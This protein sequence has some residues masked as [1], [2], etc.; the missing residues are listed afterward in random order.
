MRTAIASV[1]IL[2]LSCA[3]PAP[4]L[5]QPR[6]E[7]ARDH[8]RPAARFV[9]PQTL[10]AVPE[11]T[12][13]LKAVSCF[14]DAAVAD[15][16]DNALKLKT[17]F[18]SMLLRPLNAHPNYR[19]QMCT[20]AFDVFRRGMHTHRFAKGCISAPPPREARRPCGHQGHPRHPFL[21]GLHQGSPVLRVQHARE[22]ARAHLGVREDRPTPDGE[23]PA[24]QTGSG[25]LVRPE[26]VEGG[27]EEQPAGE[28]VPELR[29]ACSAGV[30]E[31]P[32]MRWLVVI[33][34]VFLVACEPEI[35]EGKFRCD[36]YGPYSCPV[37]F[38]CLPIAAEYQCF[39]SRGT[40]G[41]GI[42]EAGEQCD[43]DDFGGFLCSDY[44]EIYE[45]DIPQCTILCTINCSVCG[46]GYVDMHEV[47]DDGNATSG[48]GCSS[49]CRSDETCGNG[50]C[51]AVSGETCSTCPDDCPSISAGSDH[52]CAVESDGTAWCWG[53]NDRGQ[54]GNGSIE[55]SSTP[56]QVTGIVS[57][58]AVSAGTWHSCAVESDGSAWCW[59]RNYYG[60]LGNGTTEDS[61]TLVQVT[62]LTSTVAI[63]AAYYHSCAVE[64]DGSAW[65]WGYNGH[66]QLGD[67]ST[68]GSSTPVQVS[69]IEDAVAISTGK[70]HSCA[71]RTDGTVWC[72]GDGEVGQLGNGSALISS[73]PVQVS[74]LTNAVAV[75]AG[76]LHSC[77]VESDGTA[78]CWG[79]GEYGQ[80]GNGSM[81]DSS[82]PVQVKGLTNAVNISA[83]EGHSCAMLDSDTVRCWGWNWL[84]RLGN[85]IDTWTYQTIPDHVLGPSY[86][87]TISAGGAHSCAVSRSDS[88]VWCWGLNERGQLGIGSTEDSLVP[89]QVVH[90]Q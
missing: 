89:M 50:V 20:A 69:G 41:N 65:C 71:V 6:R 75:S 15:N 33:S 1:A 53:L 11:C 10:L 25:L 54:L 78:W 37:G 58:V 81:E 38:I 56:V 30:G 59:G 40:C 24:R 79:W 86:Y 83:G 52:T 68:V 16:P 70:W 21:C 63:A 84:G 44:N 42:V 90:P 85:G 12:E 18:D 17:S 55:D 87:V 31:N 82:T 88:S 66:R 51:D 43:G 2:L 72:W 61:S 8:A 23:D 29:V 35:G 80:L 62:G 19:A 47:C 28:G 4:D 74:D 48:D 27:H 49:N 60:Q 32:A 26:A 14:F 39:A 3:R 9:I 46:N 67:G 64:T 5:Q 36:P 7:P 76:G 22:G 73:T 13:Y 45:D 57:T 77:A 34:T